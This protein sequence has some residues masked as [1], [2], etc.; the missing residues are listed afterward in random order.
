M[1]KGELRLGY[2]HDKQEY[3]E[4]F[5]KVGK[6]TFTQYGRMLY[7]EKEEVWKVAADMFAN[8]TKQIN[9]VVREL[10]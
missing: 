8:I 5:L 2:I 7:M 6:E 1:T 9:A 3:W 4:Q 10:K